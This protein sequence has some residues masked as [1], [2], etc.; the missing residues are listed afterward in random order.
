MTFGTKRYGTR[1]PFL[2]AALP[3]SSAMDAMVASLASDAAKEN[4]DNT[5]VPGLG[6]VSLAL[7]LQ[8]L[9]IIFDTKM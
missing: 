4:F 1:P 6:A 7:P 8:V 5:T 9:F 2:A 3:K